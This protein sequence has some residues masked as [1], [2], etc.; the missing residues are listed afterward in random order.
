MG[1]LPT[2][3]MPAS[4]GPS[5][6]SRTLVSGDQALVSATSGLVFKVGREEA[7]PRPRTLPVGAKASILKV[8]NSIFIVK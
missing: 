4:G 6:R 1:P 3:V 5:P 2:H 8:W 7:S